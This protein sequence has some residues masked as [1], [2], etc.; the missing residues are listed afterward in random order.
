MLSAAT[1]RNSNEH[2]SI[3]RFNYTILSRLHC[4]LGQRVNVLGILIHVR[5][6][7]SDRRY[8]VDIKLVDKSRLAYPATN[9]SINS[10]DQKQIGS[11][12]LGECIYL[13]GFAV[14]SD[15]RTVSY[16]ESCEG[17]KWY[18]L[19]SAGHQIEHSKNEMPDMAFLRKW[20]ISN[21]QNLH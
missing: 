1:G 6:C 12:K 11:I 7:E 5:H 15:Y 17:S 9:V 10:H 20:W 14:C 19:E 21:C 4:Y 2:P 13:E 3:S 18:V 16:L 8:T